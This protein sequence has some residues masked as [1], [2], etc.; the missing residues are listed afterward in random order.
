MRKFV[1][2]DGK[3]VI[4]LP[5]DWLHK[6]ALYSATESDPNSFE[7]FESVGTFQINAADIGKGEIPAIIKSNNIQNQEYGKTNLD[8]VERFF[9]MGKFGMYMW[10]ARVDENF[11]ICK[12]IFDSENKNDE[13]VQLE[14]GKAR[15]A[16]KT[17]IFVPAE[18]REEI[19][20]HYQFDRF[21]FSLAGAG[22]LISRA[23]KTTNPIELVIL[24]ANQIDAL[25]RLCLILHHQIETNTKEI[26]I[27]LFSQKDDDKVVMEKGIYKMALEKGIITQ[28]LH[29]E[30]HALYNKRN[31]VVHRYIISDLT[32]K[33]VYEISIDYSAMEK[34]V[35][36][37][38]RF[39]EKEQ[40]DK[41]IG[42]YGSGDSPSR[43]MTDEEK[44]I[45]QLMIDEKHSHK[46]FISKKKSLKK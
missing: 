2:K 39:Y 45:L 35:G 38:V 3:Y 17:L 36:E 8:F 15:K 34:K 23:Y 9:E 20:T 16:L 26:D 1:D 33:D 42:M 7:L 44:T 43:E 10:F 11:L 41:K 13:K 32:T 31:K 46:S 24:L 28:K 18:I 29:D 40:Y 4:K 30:L 14:I 21:M 5:K 22:D 37:I 12:Y 25:L 19:L 6:N 27:K